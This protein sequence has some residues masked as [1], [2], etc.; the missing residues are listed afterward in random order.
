MPKLCLFENGTK[1]YIHVFI[2]VLI[3]GSMN[4]GSGHLFLI[5]KPFI[6]SIFVCEKNRTSRPLSF[7]YTRLV[8]KQSKGFI[9]R[10]NRKHDSYIRWKPLWTQ[11]NTASYFDFLENVII[12]INL[13]IV[14]MFFWSVIPSQLDALIF[15]GW[16]SQLSFQISTCFVE[17]QNTAEKHHSTQNG[18]A[19]IIGRCEIF[20]F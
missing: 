8:I 3:S 5:V 10:G 19:P 11:T 13:Q 6:L 14:Q 17:Q 15:T 2:P 12:S 1:M 16:I 4:E 7:L 18:I 20:S 9:Q